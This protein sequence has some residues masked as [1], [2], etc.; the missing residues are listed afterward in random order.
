MAKLTSQDK[1]KRYALTTKISL[2]IAIVYTFTVPLF[3]LSYKLLDLVAPYLRQYPG[4]TLET[5]T[6]YLA[7]IPLLIFLATWGT[8]R[9]LLAK[10]K[11]QTIWVVTV[12]AILVALL[13]LFL[14]F[15]LSFYFG[16]KYHYV[17]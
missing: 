16:F 13:C 9:V 8:T 12:W 4:T 14:Y 15:Y 1:V 3:D 17:F 10:E 2:I 6:Y 11:K 7:Y 5:Y